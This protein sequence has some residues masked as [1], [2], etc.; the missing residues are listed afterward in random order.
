MNRK[1]LTVRGSDAHVA[2]KAS[3]RDVGVAPTARKTLQDLA[4]T[5]R[6]RHIASAPLSERLNSM[7]VMHCVETGTGHQSRYFA[8]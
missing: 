4:L 8:L 2:I 5:E 7:A 3:S 1:A 6:N